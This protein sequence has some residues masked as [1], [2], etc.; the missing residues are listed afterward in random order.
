MSLR[1]YQEKLIE[2][3]DFLNNSKYKPK[4]DKEGFH[5]QNDLI[6]SYIEQ[7][8]SK[9]ETLRKEDDIIVSDLG[10]LQKILQLDEAI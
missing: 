1:R 3:L 10:L 2:E 5:T 6:R 7:G 4:L 8:I 9:R